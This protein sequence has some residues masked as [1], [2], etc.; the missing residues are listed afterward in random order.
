LLIFIH[1]RTKAIH[2]N[3]PDVLQNNIMSN[4]ANKKYLLIQYM[5]ILAIV[6]SNAARNIF[7]K[8]S[9]VFQKQAIMKSVIITGPTTAEILQISTSNIPNI[10]FQYLQRKSINE[11]P[12]KNLIAIRPNP[13]II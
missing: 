9:V 4:P 11:T 8:D 7:L 6:S 12:I 3:M 13:P 2:V 10:I 1:V 5:N